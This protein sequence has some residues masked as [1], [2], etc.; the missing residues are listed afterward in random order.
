MLKFRINN[1]A[2]TKK[3]IIWIYDVI[4][5]DLPAKEVAQAFNDMENNGVTK[6]VVHINSPGGNV[7]DGIA[8][9]N[10]LKERD[11]DVIIDGIA[12]SAASFIACAGKNIEMYKNA[13]M[14]IHNP[15]VF[16]G[17]DAEYM[18]K[19]SD[20]LDQIK[21]SIMSAYVDKT[22]LDSET[23]SDMMNEETW[24]NATDALENGFITKIIN[25][26]SSVDTSKIKNQFMNFIKGA[27]LM[28]REQLCVA[29]GLK[30]EATDE[31][32]LNALNL[33]KGNAEEVETLRENI[34]DL[35]TQIE[36]KKGGEKPAA[37]NTELVKQIGELKLIVTNLTQDN[38]KK[39]AEALVDQ[40]INSGK[41]IPG[42]R[43]T[44]VA[45][46]VNDVAAFAEKVK[47]MPV[48]WDVKKK[49]VKTAEDKPQAQ[50]TQGALD[51]AVAHM[52]A[53]QAVA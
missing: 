24:L 53:Q 4:G 35:Q 2:D 49:V 8:I 3:G 47:T 30:K 23:L 21:E 41:I 27:Q 11:C 18:K 29:L 31:E 51:A 28:F 25:E 13:F 19:V 7:F 6:F 12:A 50:G 44:F 45:E 36:A 46:A 52:R 15:W 48:I 43:D 26:K 22:G 40:A 42:Q 14:M 33:V 32:V 34:V 37:A 9:Y 10:M 1:L 20:Q 38:T 39:T 5:W 16:A 17:G